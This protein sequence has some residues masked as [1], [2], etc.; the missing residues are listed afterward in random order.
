ML[1]KWIS[2]CVFVS[3]SM[4]PWDAYASIHN[5]TLI[6]YSGFDTID[7]GVHSVFPNEAPGSQP[8]GLTLNG[9]AIVHNR[10][11]G[12]SP[13]SPPHYIQIDNQ[14]DAPNQIL[15]EL[16]GSGVEVTFELTYAYSPQPGVEERSN[17]VEIYVRRANIEV[18]VDQVSESG[19]FVPEPEPGQ[20]SPEPV[21]LFDTVWTERTVSFQGVGVGDEFSI[22]F[23]S[24][25]ILDS[26]GGYI[27]N[28]RL[29]AH[30]TVAEPATFMLLAAGMGGAA[31]ICLGR[32]KGPQN[33]RKA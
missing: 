25:G 19:F 16:G 15:L 1:N 23:R 4:L 29:V 28:I 7:I 5:P 11:T 21:P 32:K 33:R 14:N 9:S 27:D 17:K 24:G 31:S 13:L 2:R 3:A 8:F 18:L 22:A 30:R 26:A 20:P 10:M 6:Y 12:G